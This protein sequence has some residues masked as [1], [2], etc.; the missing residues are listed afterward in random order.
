M[1]VSLDQTVN[2]T[3]MEDIVM[4]LLRILVIGIM[5]CHME[6]D[7]IL[8]IKPARVIIWPANY[9]RF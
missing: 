3:G 6:Q 4:R 1:K 5:D 2:Q 9:V 8:S 7:G